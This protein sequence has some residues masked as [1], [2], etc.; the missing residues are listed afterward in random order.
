MP[1]PELPE[2]E[3]ITRHLRRELLN[4]RFARVIHCRRDVIRHGHYRELRSF[5]NTPITRI[6]RRGKRPFLEIAD[7]RG[8]VFFLG[9]TGRLSVCDSTTAVENHTHLRLQLGD[10]DRELRFNDARRFGGFGFYTRRN[11]CEPVGIDG[12]GPE[13]LDVTAP[14]FRDICARDRQIKALLLDQKYIAGLGNIYADE[15]LFRAGIHPLTP[16]SNLDAKQVSRLLRAIKRVLTEAIEYEGTT[17]INYLHP[18]GPGNFQTRLRVYGH[19]GENC[20]RCKVPI[21]RMQVAGRSSFVCPMCQPPA[22]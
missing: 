11:E 1:M 5:L 4:K 7:G 9:M 22:A 14:Q 17:I 2:A 10:S 18:D 21:E 20:R 8:I 16:A 12:L 19:E 6:D 13:P 3:T 15:S